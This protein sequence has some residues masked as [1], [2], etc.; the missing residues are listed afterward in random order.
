MALAWCAGVLAALCSMHI[1]V[2]VCVALV[3]YRCSVHTQMLIVI[4]LRVAGCLTRVLAVVE[5]VYG[6]LGVLRSTGPG[7][8]ML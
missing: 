8:H 1:C 6:F 5:V 3:S 7:T 2:R 4:L